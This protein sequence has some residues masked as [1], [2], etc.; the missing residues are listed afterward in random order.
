MPSLPA[1]RSS[2]GWRRHQFDS[3][4]SCGNPGLLYGRPSCLNAAC[5]SPARV[6]SPGIRCCIFSGLLPVARAETSH[7]R[8]PRPRRAPCG[9]PLAEKALHQR[10]LI[11][12]VAGLNHWSVTAAALE[13]RVSLPRWRGRR[14]A[15]QPLATGS[16]AWVVLWCWSEQTDGL[17]VLLRPPAR[18]A[19]LRDR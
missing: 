5:Y 17:S 14:A 1:E 13:S 10:R 8:R 16:T 12:R 4:R 3:V 6:I 18:C 19:R 15:R 9:W 11:G 7:Y 2:D